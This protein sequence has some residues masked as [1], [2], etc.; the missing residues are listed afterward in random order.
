MKKKILHVI[1]S[2]IGGTGSVT[3][4]IISADKKKFF[5]SEVLFIGVEKVYSGY[6]EWCKHNKIKYYVGNKDYN[7]LQ[8]DI[9]V[10]KTVIK[11][12]PD[13]LIFHNDN[14]I[15]SALISLIRGIKLV[16]IE[17]N[18]Y[19]YRNFK[20]IIL[21]NF[22]FIFFNKIVYLYDDYLNRILDRNVIAKIFKKKAIVINNGI[23]KVK[24]PFKIKSK[25]FRIG[26]VSR[27][28]KGKL[29][30]VLVKS[31]DNL[32]SK[33]ILI[34]LMLVG[35]GENYNNISHEI[36]LRNLN[37]YVSL[38]KSIPENKLKKW[39]SNLDLYC[40]LSIDEG[41]STA[42]LHAMSNNTLLLVSKNKGNNFLGNNAI[43]TKNNTE[44]V[45]KK[46]VIIKNNFFKYRKKINKA[47]IF[48]NNNFT[49]TIMFK[50][51][52]NLI[53]EFYDK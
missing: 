8:R 43:Y 47:N 4:S 14:F 29:Q 37:K 33:G 19:A 51:Y 50:K 20:N 36:K 24:N 28:S 25:Y 5:N 21:L 39:F 53:T 40:H 16:Y 2:G 34:K 41:L 42:I 35:Y 48:F 26:M 30:Q 44:D 18:P 12:K 27:F 15:T 49:N 45:S 17:H 11:F 13:V 31:M 10:A 1:Y 22:I 23:T 46:I 7:F 9:F 6:I 38:R 32:K 52:K 3:T